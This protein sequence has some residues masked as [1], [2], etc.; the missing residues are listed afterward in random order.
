MQTGQ[1]TKRV[2]LGTQPFVLKE[3]RN[4]KEGRNSGRD[5]KKEKM[6]FRLLLLLCL[7]LPSYVG[8]LLLPKRGSVPASIALRGRGMIKFECC[9]TRR[10][11]DWI[12]FE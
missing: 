10:K 8:N 12:M 1:P 11:M 4:I 7:R 5:G 2:G 9:S 3:G 6:F